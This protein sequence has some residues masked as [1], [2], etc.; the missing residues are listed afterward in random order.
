M[1]VPKSSP[2][3]GYPQVFHRKARKDRKGSPYFRK[4]G[5]LNRPEF[6][7]STLVFSPLSAGNTGGFFACFAS[8]AVQMQRL[9][10]RG[11]GEPGKRGKRP[12]SPGSIRRNALLGDGDGREGRPAVV[13]LGRHHLQ[14]TEDRDG[15]L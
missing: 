9:G 12:D 14:V 7:G 15:I 4:S 2:R 1:A 8:F 5:R 3:D 10:Y 11:N 6:S 13:I